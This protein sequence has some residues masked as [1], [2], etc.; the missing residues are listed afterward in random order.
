MVYWALY[1]ACYT[2]I[3]VMLLLFSLNIPRSVSDFLLTA[4]D[5][6]LLLLVFAHFDFH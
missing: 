3:A 5:M 6:P 4:G 2:A 1:P